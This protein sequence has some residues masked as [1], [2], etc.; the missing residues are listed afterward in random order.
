MILRHTLSLFICCFI[1]LGCYGQQ[2]IVGR[3]LNDVLKPVIGASV[4]NKSTNLHV[5]TD[6][7]G[8]YHIQASITDTIK[9]LSI[10]LTP[11]NRVV[12]EIGKN[13]NIILINKDVNC[14]GAIWSERRYKK[15]YRQINNRYRKLYSLASAKK[16]W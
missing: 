16:L 9:F 11:E 2:S 15:A 1:S 12:K 4:I 3:V 13:I 6:K 8:D 10:G 5:N 14:L 7:N